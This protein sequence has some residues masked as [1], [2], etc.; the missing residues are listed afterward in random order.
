MNP[1]LLNVLKLVIPVA[2]V[3]AAAVAA[4]TLAAMRPEP[5]TQRPEAPVPLVRTFTARVGELQLSVLSQGT[6]SPRTE[7]SVA[8][9]VGGRV[10]WVSPS[11]V[12]GGFFEAGSPLLRLDTVDYQQAVVRAEAEVA[13]ARL[14]LAQEEAEARVARQEWEELGGG[15]APELTAR[16]PQLQNA[17]A[18]LAAAEAAL[19][20]SRRDLE[21]TEIRAPYAGRVRDKRFDVG[22]FVA[23][24]ADL[25][26]I[27]AIDVA[28]IRLPLPD[29][30]LAYLDLPLMYRGEAAGRGPAVRLIAD[31]A[32]RR[33]EWRGRIVRTEGQIDPATRMVHVVAQ[34]SDPYGRGSDPQRPPLAVG[35][36]VRAEI[37]GLA[38]QDVAEIPRAAVRAD[39]R[40][41]VVD[42]DN[43]LHFRD[44]QV[45]RATRDTIVLSSGVADGERVVVSALD[46]VTEGMRV[47]V[48]QDEET[49][50]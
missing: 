21:R 46:T 43:R 27:Y 26:S 14:R 38:L 39:G 30:E 25:G 1:R 6:V 37:E 41:L 24:G 19:E 15:E 29:D 18:S 42:A 7:S 34:V 45:A 33:H 16:I 3:A 10:V 23:P 40:I 13:A 44:I 50:R 9:E 49:P 22:Q 28:E 4:M 36:Y 31:F 8:P 20:R 2:V 47:R 17:R 48:G 5:E 32:G 35:M 11:F 12:S